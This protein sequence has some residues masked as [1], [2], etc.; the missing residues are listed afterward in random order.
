[1][2]V[3]DGS[4]AVDYL[5]GDADRAAWVEHELNVGRWDIH[6]PHVIDVE[7]FSTLRRIALGRRS[8]AARMVDALDLARRIAMTRYPHVDLLDRMWT[9]RH[10]LHPPDSAYVALA[11]ALD[12]PL[13]TTDIRL[14]RSHGHAAVIVSP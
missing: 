3:L 4:A 7:V 10:T 5:V 12:A 9:L 8:V 14:A 6:A 11:E 13:V 1:V 2:I